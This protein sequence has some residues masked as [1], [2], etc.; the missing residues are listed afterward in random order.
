MVQKA[1]SPS[2]KEFDASTE[3]FVIEDGNAEEKRPT[4]GEDLEH[5]RQQNGEQGLEQKLEAVNREP[6]SDEQEQDENSPQRI[7]ASRCEVQSQEESAEGNGRIYERVLEQT[8]IAA[9]RSANVAKVASINVKKFDESHQ[10][11]NKVKK[12]AKHVGQHV[13]QTSAK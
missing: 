6:S 5:T 4:S 2:F 12:T 8:K 3:F 11:S 13:R 7:V 10:V 1:E 9:M